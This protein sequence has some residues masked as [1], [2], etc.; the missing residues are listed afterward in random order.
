MDAIIVGAS[1]A[2]FDGDTVN[3]QWVKDGAVLDSGTITSPAGGTPVEI[4]DLAIAGRR[5][6][7]LPGLE[8][9]AA[10]DQRWRESGSD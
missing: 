9:G 5:S 4:D 6:A 10:R 1:V 8:S 7:V 3:Y 2:D